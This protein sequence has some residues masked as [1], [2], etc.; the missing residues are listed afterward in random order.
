MTD[1]RLC[2]LCTTRQRI[3]KSTE[4]RDAVLAFVGEAPGYEEDRLGVPF[5]GAAGQLL[6]RMLSAMNLS[7]S[8]VLISN[9]VRCRPPQNRQPER[10]EIEAC[11]PFLWQTL[12][13]ASK[14]RFIVTLGNTPLRVL[15][16]DSHAKISQW[17]GSWFERTIGERTFRVMP[18]FHPAYLL[19]NPGEKM[20]VWADLQ[21]VMG[22]LQN[23][24]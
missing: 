17:R 4:S 22:V 3:V 13:S 18:T 5:V 20:K 21:A 10:D 11:L 23:A 2:K 6:D 7:R 24:G 9:V 15:S 19:R 14:L 1:C 12:E 16:G 8:E